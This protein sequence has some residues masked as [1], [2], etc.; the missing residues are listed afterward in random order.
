MKKVGFLLNYD[1]HSWLGGFNVKKNLINSFSLVEKQ[2]IRPFII[3]PNSFKKFYKKFQIP[4]NK[5]IFT[6]FF[7]K[8]T[9]LFKLFNK[10]L[11]IFLGRSYIYDNFFRS[12]DISIV[13]HGLNFGLGSKS[14]IKSISWIPDFQHIYYPEYFSNRARIFKYINTIFSA[15]SSTRIILS[16]KD[17][18]KDLKKVLPFEY[19]KTIVHPYVFDLPKKNK[20]INLK[21]LI[22]K[23]HIRKNYFYIPNQFWKHK[24]H[25][26]VI[27][28]L[29][30]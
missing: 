23:Y 17:V 20:I 24:N 26:L 6:D 11:I 28:T 9:P 8:Q 2:K 3:A 25:D 1:P 15:L 19:N 30:Y 12:I 10:I 29:N 4:K 13:S 5:I 22:K 27:E 21:N 16:S 14:S 7:V 18:K